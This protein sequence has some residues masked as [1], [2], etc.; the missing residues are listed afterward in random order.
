MLVF[1]H[2]Y[3]IIVDLIYMD[4]AV[5]DHEFYGDPSARLGG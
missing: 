5:L 1:M 3:E 4:Y 2:R